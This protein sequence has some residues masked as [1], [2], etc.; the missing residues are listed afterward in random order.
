M[1][2]GGAL[3]S[4]ALVKSALRVRHASTHGLKAYLA[5]V[6]AGVSATSLGA[7]G[8]WAIGS[9]AADRS[10]SGYGRWC[11]LGPDKHRAGREVVRSAGATR[12]AR[13]AA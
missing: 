3:A 1:L 13:S 7:L 6:I 2:Y 4:G 11:H 10:S 5:V 8:G 12:G 9:T